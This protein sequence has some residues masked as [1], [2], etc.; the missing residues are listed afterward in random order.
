MDYPYPIYQYGLVNGRNTEFAHTIPGYTFVKA[1]VDGN[2]NGDE[3]TH[4]GMVWEDKLLC[5]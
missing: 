4:L 3:I 1:T 2:Q 5:Q